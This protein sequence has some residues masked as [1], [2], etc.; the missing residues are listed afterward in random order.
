MLNARGPRQKRRQL[1]A[2][3]AKSV[4]MYAAPVWSDALSCD[5]YARELRSVYRRLCLRVCSAF[6]TVSEDAA[7]VIAGLHPIDLLAVEATKNYCESAANRES[8]RSEVLKKWQ[9]RWDASEKGRWTHQ[10][11]PNIEKW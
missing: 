10:L 4:I 2:G 11:I 7:L 8:R 3:V 6:R 9:D 5:T 1:L